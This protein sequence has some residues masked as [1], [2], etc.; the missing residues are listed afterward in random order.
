MG[1]LQRYPEF[2]DQSATDAQ[3]FEKASDNV[4]F[5]NDTDCSKCLRPFNELGRRSN[6]VNIIT[7]LKE[8]IWCAEC[9]EQGIEEGICIQ[10]SKLS[11]EERKLWKKKLKQE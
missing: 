5:V 6:R 9:V 8:D 4:L 1:L 11:K 3:G 7:N 2:P 10:E